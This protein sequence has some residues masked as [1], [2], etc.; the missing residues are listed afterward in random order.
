M[1]IDIKTEELLSLAQAAAKLPSRRAGRKTHV[2][3]LHRWATSGLHGQVLETVQ[4]G[5][6][7]VTSLPALQRFFERLAAEKSSA[8]STTSSSNA[9]VETALDREGI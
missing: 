2:A 8:T 6:G 9:D 4:C 7:R 3:T 1:A 5:G